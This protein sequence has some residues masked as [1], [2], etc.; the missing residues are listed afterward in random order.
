M[1]EVQLATLENVPE[2]GTGKVIDVEHPIT[3]FDFQLALFQV[4]GKFYALDNECVRCGGKLGR[5]KLNGMYVMCPQDDTPWNIKSGLC[6]FDR[7]R[8]VPSYKVRMENDILYT[9][10]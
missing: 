4:N 9:N 5:G 2:E 7:T 10:I 1:A 8:S 6:K 3:A